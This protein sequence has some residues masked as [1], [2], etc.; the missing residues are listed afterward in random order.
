MAKVMTSPSFALA[1]AA[2][3]D[4]AP[5]SA[6]VVT[7]TAAAWLLTGERGNQQMIVAITAFQ[8]KDDRALI[9]VR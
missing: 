7:T 1:M 8:G 4:P 5:L 9:S 6:S 2:R 3:S